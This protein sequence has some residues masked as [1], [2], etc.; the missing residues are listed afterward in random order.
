MALYAYD[1][2]GC[3]RAFE[4]R[5][6]MAEADNTTCPHCGNHHPKRQLSRISVK[7]QSSQNDGGRATA[8]VGG[9]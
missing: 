7:G 2:P 6:P 1:C 5:V 3:G 4:K 8:P 9:G